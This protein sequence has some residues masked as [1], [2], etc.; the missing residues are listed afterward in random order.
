MLQEDDVLGRFDGYLVSIE[1]DFTGF[2]VGT[3]DDH[4]AVESGTD[5]D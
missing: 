3:S 4:E 2:R 1:D 5:A